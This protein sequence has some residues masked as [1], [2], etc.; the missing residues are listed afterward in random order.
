MYRH[1]IGTAAVT[2]A[3]VVWALSSFFTIGLVADAGGD[4]CHDSPCFVSAS[5]RSQ[6]IG[7]GIALVPAA[8]SGVLVIGLWR[9]FAGRS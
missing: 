7:L 8:L 3:F 2:V 5:E 6:M 1:G 9:H 4:T